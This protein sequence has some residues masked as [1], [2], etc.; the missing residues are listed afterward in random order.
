MRTFSYFS[1]QPQMRLYKLTLKDLAVAAGA[2]NLPLADS[3]RSTVGKRAGTDTLQTAISLK[4]LSKA[5]IVFTEA[6]R[7]PNYFV[8]PEAK[9]ALAAVDVYQ[10]PPIHRLG[11]YPI[12]RGAH[13]DLSLLDLSVL[14]RVVNSNMTRLEIVTEVAKELD[15]NPGVAVASFKTLDSHLGYIGCKRGEQ[16]YEVWEDRVADVQAALSTYAHV[17]EVMRSGYLDQGVSKESAQ[18]MGSRVGDLLTGHENISRHLKAK[19]FFAALADGRSGGE[20]KLVDRLRTC[21]MELVTSSTGGPSAAIL[22]MPMLSFAVVEAL[23]DNEMLSTADVAAVTGE[24]FDGAYERIELML[25]AGFIEP[26]DFGKNF[27]QF[28]TLSPF[29]RSSLATFGE[30]LATRN[31]LTQPIQQTS[32]A[33]SLQ[34]GAQL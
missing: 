11:G 1:L 24:S 34:S 3:R 18:A 33:S 22:E 14:D 30:A 12:P 4:R 23:L 16:V 31:A 8:L 15:V 26:T 19:R 5:A 7:H 21:S 25:A 20:D 13:G 6:G 32:K 17:F 28:V 29:G 10:T 9:V 2:L 27:G